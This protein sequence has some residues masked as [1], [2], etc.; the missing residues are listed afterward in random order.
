MMTKDDLQKQRDKLVAALGRAES[1][2]AFEG[3]KTEF[4][5]PGE[6]LQAIAAI[7]SQLASGSRRVFVVASNGGLGGCSCGRFC[8]S[9]GDSFEAWR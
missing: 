1:S 3:R 2:I 4:R 5:T 8:C 7:D 6:L 9:C